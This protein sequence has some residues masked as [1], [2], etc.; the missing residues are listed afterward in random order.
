MLGGEQTFGK[1]I[2]QSFFPLSDGSGVKLTTARYFTPSGTDI[3]GVGVEPNIE[4]END[5]ETEEDEQLQK[6]IEE[7]K[8]Q[9]K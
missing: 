1:G 8:K 3:H 6:A 7:V 9:E 5:P 2:I 4:V